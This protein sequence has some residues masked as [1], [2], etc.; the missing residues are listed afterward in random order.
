LLISLTEIL[1]SGQSLKMELD[2]TNVRE[3]WEK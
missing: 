2:R 3:L 1:K